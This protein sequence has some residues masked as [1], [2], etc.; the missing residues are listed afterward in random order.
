LAATAIEIPTT[1]VDQVVPALDVDARLLQEAGDRDL[2]AKVR[3]LGS[4]IQAARRPS[5]DADVAVFLDTD[6]T[7]EAR[8]ALERLIRTLPGVTSVAYESQQQAY[9]RF[10]E[11][12]KNQP[13]LVQS[14]SA[15]SLP[16]S[17]LIKLSDQSVRGAIT[18]KLESQTGVNAVQA[19]ARNFVMVDVGEEVESLV[20]AVNCPRLFPRASP[21]GRPIVQRTSDRLRG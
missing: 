21:Y 2:A 5:D 7:D 3:A 8:A 18:T 19:P 16:S 12:F 1:I 4:K 13:E 14:I 6:V 20:K 9:A 15:S 10:K 17:F 11:I